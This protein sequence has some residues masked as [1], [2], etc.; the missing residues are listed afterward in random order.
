[1]SSQE[2]IEQD[3][4]SAP[5]LGETT[6]PHPLPKRQMFALLLLMTAEPLMGLSIMPYINEV[7]PLLV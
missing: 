5:L 6:H 7:C 1:M 2:L 4:E 3:E